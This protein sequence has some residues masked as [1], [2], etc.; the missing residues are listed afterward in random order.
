VNVKVVISFVAAVAWL[1]GCGDSGSNDVV[2][3][4]DGLAQ[5]ACAE[6]MHQA[7]TV[8]SALSPDEA[9]DE[10]TVHV[11]EPV[12]IELAG[13]TSYVALE[14]PSPH[15]DYAI[16]TQPAGVLQA[17]ST[18]NLSEEVINGACP[19]DDMGDNRLHIHEFEYSVLT[20]EGAGT[21]WLYAAQAG[22]SGHHDDG[23][24]HHE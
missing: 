19:Q 21:V 22:A 2:G 10:S 7:E 12:N 3:A 8:Q 14:V 11:G 16:F 17:T 6:T 13:P 20:L 15:T 1:A 24:A 4:D 18:T 5:E 23:D 9:I